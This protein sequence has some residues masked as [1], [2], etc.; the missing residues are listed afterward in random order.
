[1]EC[2]ECVSITSCFHYCSP[3]KSFSFF[4]TIIINQKITLSLPLF[5]IFLFKLFGQH[6]RSALVCHKKIADRPDLACK[7]W[8]WHTFMWW[9]KQK[10][11]KQTKKKCHKGLLVNIVMNQLPVY[12]DGSAEVCVC[13]CLCLG[14]CAWGGGTEGSSL[15]ISTQACRNVSWLWSVCVCAQQIPGPEWRELLFY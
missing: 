3:S 5:F 4:K 10:K 2:V 12:P 11:Q 1:M 7:P 13:V 14:I 8:V 6:I 9:P 15:F